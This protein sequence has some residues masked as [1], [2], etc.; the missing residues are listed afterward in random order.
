M[1]RPPIDPGWHTPI[2]T[3][4]LAIP[5]PRR[6]TH[7][8]LLCQR[9]R[10]E[11]RE[12]PQPQRCP[13]CGQLLAH[14]FHLNEQ[15]AAPRGPGRRSPNLP[16]PIDTGERSD[17]SPHHPP[18][19]KQTVG[20]RPQPPSL[21]DFILPESGCEVSSSLNL[22]R[23]YTLEESAR[24][25]ARARQASSTI[26]QRP[27]ARP[28]S[29]PHQ[30]PATG[31]SDDEKLPASGRLVVLL[32]VAIVVSIIVSIAFILALNASTSTP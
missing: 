14:E 29:S 30:G 10:A 20:T 8:G 13:H 4:P 15:I 17:L 2:T 3:D 18:K 5:A 32:F 6:T 24:V 31:H 9:C 11:I 28:Q 26:L 22:P 7:Q 19:P 21:T 25:L 1:T 23:P 16:I 12:A 27:V